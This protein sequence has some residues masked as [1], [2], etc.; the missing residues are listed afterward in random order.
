MAWNRASRL[1]K[2]LRRAVRFQSCGSSLIHSGES[3]IN[4]LIVFRDCPANAI[5]KREIESVISV[6]LH[7]MKAVKCRRGQYAIP[8]ETSE[9]FRVSLVS[10]MAI[11]V[12]D[13]L[14]NGEDKKSR[15][16][17]GKQENDH[18]EG[19]PVQECLKRVV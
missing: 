5:P 4:R 3:A 6:E 11:R 1:R 13:C 15:R 9:P 18:G 17:N 8:S 14:Q 10:A 19:Q 7:V 2:N 16:M 12:G